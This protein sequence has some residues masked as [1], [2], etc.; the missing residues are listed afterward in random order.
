MKK[1]LII[2]SSKGIGSACVD[3]FQSKGHAIDSVSR[4][5][6]TIIGDITNYEFR[7][8]LYKTQRPDVIINSA[9]VPGL[10][11]YRA[12]MTNYVAAAELTMNFY[13]LLN[14][15]SD[16]INISSLASTESQGRV[17]YSPDGIVYSSTKNAISDICV[18]LAVR[19]ARDVRVTALEPAM[20]MP[21]DLAPVTRVSIPEENY[22]NFTFEKRAPIKPSYIP[23]V[24]DWIINQPRWV[25]VGRLTLMNNHRP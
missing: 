23:E 16:I 20:V 9:G 11:V 14:P 4:T 2:G 10:P 5:S 21:T 1:I 15:G 3:Y 22:T 13:E 8:H 19:R 17:G 12:I 18:S 24:I 6:G 25:N 7:Q